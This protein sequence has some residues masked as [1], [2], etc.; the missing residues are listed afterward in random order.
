MIKSLFLLNFTFAILA[1]VYGIVLINFDLAMLLL[2]FG[3][4]SNLALIIT[5][6]INQ[7]GLLLE[8]KLLDKEGNLIKYVK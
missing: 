3:E 1:Y 4:A 2:C 7:I 8:D 5:N 6:F